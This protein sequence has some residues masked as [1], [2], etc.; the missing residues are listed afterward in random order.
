MTVLRQTISVNYK[1]LDDHA[2][3]G[4]AGN[5]ARGLDGNRD[6]PAPTPSAA[7]GKLL[8]DSFTTAIGEAQTNG[9]AAVIRK[10]QLRK[11]VE[12]LLDAWS[13]YALD[14][15]PNNPLVWA[16]ANFR[17]T[18]AERAKARP[19]A[20]PTKFQTLEGPRRGTVRV[21]QSAQR[22][23][24]VY[25]VEYGIVDNTGQVAHWFYC[26]SPTADCLVENL[27]S[28]QAYLFRAAA[29]N[30]TSAPSFSDP[31]RRIVQ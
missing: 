2:L 24:R 22:G 15:R 5:V 7:D 25:V 9:H 17:L 14:T 16:E 31:E 26:L 30:G 27:Q 12:D 29:W 11:Q 3:A 19:L 20:A 21:R 6:L 8:I 23:C 28:G 4:Y 13:D 18:K 10:N 1:D